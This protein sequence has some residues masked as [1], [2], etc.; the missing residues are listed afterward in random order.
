MTNKT[1]HRITF[2]TKFGAFQAV[3]M[4]G[5]PDCDTAAMELQKT[6]Y[7]HGC[8]IRKVEAIDADTPRIWGEQI[9]DYA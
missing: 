9:F 6:F 4:L 8:E 1:A 7:Y 5:Q 2:I 3:R